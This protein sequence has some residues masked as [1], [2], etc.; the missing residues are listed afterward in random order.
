MTDPPGYPPIWNDTDAMSSSYYRGRESSLA[1]I[2][3]AGSVEIG[4]EHVELD[5]RRYPVVDDVIITLAPA[6]L[7]TSVRDRLGLEPQGARGSGMFAEDIQYTFGAEWVEHGEVLPEHH[8][9]FERYFD[10]VDLDGL[11]G[12]R[13]ADL[14]CGSGRWATFIAPRCREI[15]LVDFSEAV[16]VAR[17]NLRSVDNAVFVLDDV[18]SLP[19]ADDAFALSYCL[20]VLHHLPVNALDA[21]RRLSRLGPDLVVYLYYSLDNR[22]A[23]YRTALRAVSVVRS[24]LARIRS[25][26]VRSALSFA[27]AATV[28]APLALVGRIGGTRAGRYVPL[29]DTYAG[30]SIR[31]LQQDAYDR[32][33][34]RIEQRFSRQEIAA[35]SDT[36]AQV[37][38][39]D[40][41]PYWHFHCRR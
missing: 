9:E 32:F 22:P 28:Y 15:V 20:G 23:Y 36:F 24:R 10:L 3:G 29:A 1:E 31:R 25:R 8:Q 5:G 11:A 6:R 17:Q 14:G 40:G 26:R 13:V 7:P 2:F 4:A 16:F 35:L 18:L 27:I 21:C 34:T 41:L 38:I 12:R 19:F 30:A 39:S 33:F 37:T